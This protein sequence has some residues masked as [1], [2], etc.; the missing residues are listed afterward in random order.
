MSTNGTC[1]FPKHPFLK[2]NKIQKFQSYDFI[3]QSCNLKSH[4]Y[5]HSNDTAEAETKNY[6]VQLPSAIRSTYPKFIH[7]HINDTSHNCYEVKNIPR[8]VEVIL[9]MEIKKPLRLS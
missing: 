3:I 5:T 7:Q 9:L 4:T 2:S 1:N 8:V 6:I